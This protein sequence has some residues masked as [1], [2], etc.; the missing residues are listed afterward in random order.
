MSVSLGMPIYAII[1]RACTSSVGVAV[2][3]SKHTNTYTCKHRYCFGE[4]SAPNDSSTNVF[5]WLKQ[6]MARNAHLRKQG[7]LAQHCLLHRWMLEDSLQPIPPPLRASNNDCRFPL[8]LVLC[9]KVRHCVVSSYSADRDEVQ[10][11]RRLNSCAHAT[12]CPHANN[13]MVLATWAMDIMQ[14]SLLPIA[15]DRSVL[16]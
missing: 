15:S 8:R 5:S 2:I 14:T 16:R 4:Y 11:G 7:V 10:Q 12:E 6:V 13:L 1:L 3:D 9:V